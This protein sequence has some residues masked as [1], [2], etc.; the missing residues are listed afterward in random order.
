[1][2]MTNKMKL[3]GT[4]AVIAVIITSVFIG[5]PFAKQMEPVN[6]EISVA[7][8]INNVNM[9]ERMIRFANYFEL[10][11]SYSDTKVIGTSAQKISI[12]SIRYNGPNAN[13]YALGTV[14]YVNGV[15][16]SALFTLIKNN[17]EATNVVIYS[18]I[19]NNLRGPIT[20]TINKEYRTIHPIY[21]NVH[22][23]SVSYGF[24]GIAIPLNQQQTIELTALMSAG[25]AIAAFIAAIVGVTVVGGLVAAIVS[26]VLAL[27]AAYITFMD[28]YGD[29]NGI[30]IDMSYWGGGFISA[31]EYDIPWGY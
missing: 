6:T 16:H 20:F 29:F 4:T 24:L 18:I 23:M 5:V 8:S 2:E 30:N 1:M 3:L 7:K 10:R 22:P 12:E 28:A 21:P 14:V 19:S 17:G 26:L 31:P 25:S 13:K 11:E 27:G 9:N 15:V